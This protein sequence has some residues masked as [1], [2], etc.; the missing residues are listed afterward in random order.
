ML[1]EEK[2]L[3]LWVKFIFLVLAANDLPAFLI[4]MTIPGLTNEWFVWTVKPDASARLLGVMYA[5]A[6]LLVGLGLIQP[7]W[8]RARITMVVITFFSVAATIVTFF[9]LDPFLKH[10][11]YH[12]AYWLSLYL[13]LFA[14]APLVFFLQERKNGG[15]LVS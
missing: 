7:D 3:S 2:K 12:L 15:K 4:L 9:N 11:W 5:N 8:G 10:P 6:L 14:S 1:R 13:I